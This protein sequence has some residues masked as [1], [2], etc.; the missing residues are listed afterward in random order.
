[1]PSSHVSILSHSIRNLT[2]ELTGRGIEHSIQTEKSAMK[3]VQSALRLN[4]LLY[5]A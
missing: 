5:R 4:D 1:L 3:A 2:P